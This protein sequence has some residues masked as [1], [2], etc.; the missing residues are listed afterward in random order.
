[1]LIPRDSLADYLIQ[2]ANVPAKSALCPA[3]IRILEGLIKNIICLLAEPDSRNRLLPVFKELCVK[4]WQLDEQKGLAVLSE[5]TI[6]NI[7]KAVVK[8]EDWSFLE[9]AAS[10]L[11]DRTP[12]GFFTWVAD[13]LVSE[14]LSFAKLERRFEIL[15]S[16][17]KKMTRL[18]DRKLA[19]C[20]FIFNNLL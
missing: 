13:Q 9:E 10:H 17:Q 14:S 11:G 6:Q 3:Q 1:M 7:L 18:T 5:I 16:L 19:G 12:I 20:R 8:A 15:S 4:I 2:Y